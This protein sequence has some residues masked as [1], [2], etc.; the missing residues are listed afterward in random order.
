MREHRLQARVQLV[1]SDLFAALA[2]RR[3]DVIVTNPPY[4]PAA[5]MR[6]LP[7][8]YRHEPRLALAGGRRGLDLVRRIVAEAPRHLQPRGLLMC[9]VGD[10][11]SVVER[12]FPRLPLL[13]PKAEVFIVQSAANSA[14]GART[15]PSA[16]RP[17]R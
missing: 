6:R 12:A 14:P 2:G 17:P 1:R 11:R 7:P 3:Y 15:P 4:V 16:R 10:G 9:E 5:V 8:E 13:W